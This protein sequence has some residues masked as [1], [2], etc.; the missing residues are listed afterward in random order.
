MKLRGDVTLASDKLAVERL[1]AEFDRKTITG[2]F[3]YGFAGAQPA[4]LDAVLNAP[5][6]DVDAALGFG[7]ALF[8]GS[9]IAAPHEMTIAADI[10]RATFAGIVA[11]SASARLK[12]DAGGLQ[13]DKLSVADLGGAAFSAS[14]RIA[15]AAPSPQGDMRVDLDAPDMAPVMALL[16]RLAP[17]TALSLG[18]SA[19]MMA[20]TKLHARLTIDGAASPPLAKLGLDG[21]LGKVRLA[22]NAQAGVDSILFNVGDIRLDGKL[23]AD[24]GKVLVAMLGLD[25]TVAAEAGP[26]TLAVKAGGPA[27]GELKIESRL[28]AGGLDAALVGTANLF[29]DSRSA[30]LRATIIRADISPL[31]GP[32]GGPPLPLAFAARLSANGTDVSFADINATVGGA[33]VRGKLSATWQRP[34]NVQGDIEADSVDGAAVV[35]AAIGMPAAAGSKSGSGGPRNSRTVWTWSSEPFAQGG[36]G[37][38]TG[39]VALKARRLDAS[40]RLTARE[41]RAT[42]RFGKDELVF[43]D[44]S[45]EV[46]G[47]RLTARLSFHNGAEGLETNIKLG[48]A[49]ADAAALLPS[50]AR[51][52]VSG[53]LALSAEM[54][55]AGLSPVALIGSLQ[56]NGKLTLSDSQFS[57]LDPR[58]FDAV[59]RAVDQGLPIDAGRIG[60]VVQKAL[61]SGQLSVKRAESSIAVSTGQMRLTN[62]ALESKDADLSL[63]GNLDLTDGSID[64]RMVLSGSTRAAGARPDIF[65]AL[66]GSALAPVRSIDVS[67]LAGWLTLRAVENQTRQLRA[68]E[69]Q[70]PKPEVPPLAPKSELAPALPAPI[71]IRPA[72]AP[73]Q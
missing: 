71:D 44:V 22:M 3:A 19:S 64:A 47:G 10:G 35:A 67:A 73:A 14:G 53:A 36:F 54:K 30:A 56:G 23:D 60:E 46:A 48:L 55:G 28:T 59:T 1:Q 43:D 31:R 72:P 4:K 6:F 15:M 62:V 68:I 63:S 11:R 32:D 33:A 25:R 40:P 58:A 8:S 29:G 41:F 61:E 12:V 57:G 17:E 7:K 2:R 51:P 18:R 37:D 21:S 34:R 50:G 16:A 27:R 52:S 65:M 45:G 20:P 42:L 5:E 66:Q 13:I 70:P 9:N 49:N 39:Q 26:G 24:D 38:F 69:A